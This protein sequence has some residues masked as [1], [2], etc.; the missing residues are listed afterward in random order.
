MSAAVLLAMPTAIAA[1][2]GDTGSVAPADD[3]AF[4]GMVA[5]ETAAA[6]TAPPAASTTTSAEPATPVAAPNQVHALVSAAVAFALQPRLAAGGTAVE[7]TGTAETDANV[8]AAAAESEDQPPADPETTIG[9]SDLSSRT[10]AADTDQ[11]A[12]DS[13]ASPQPA[14]VLL[15]E[16]VA[17][18]VKSAASDDA[19]NRHTQAA[20]PLPTATTPDQASLAP[21]EQGQADGARLEAPAAPTDASPDTSAL[22]PTATAA[23]AAAQAL[24]ALN[25]SPTQ[26]LLTLAPEQVSAPVA[27]RDPSRSDQTLTA[28]EPT[29]AGKD[30]LPTETPLSKTG[31]TETKSSEA[32][33]SETSPSQMPEGATS[34]TSPDAGKAM[35][36]V[37]PASAKPAEGPVQPLAPSVEPVETATPPAANLAQPSSAPAST[38]VTAQASTLSLLSQATI[39]TTAQIAAQISKTL[40]GRSTRFEMGLTPEGL[41]RVDVSLEIDA[42]GQLAARLAFDNPLAATELRGRVDDLRREL[43]DAGFTIARDGLEFA[44]RQSSS[45]GG[46]DRRQGR[47]FAS[48]SRI[49]ADADLSTPAPAAWTSL[50]LTPRGVDLKV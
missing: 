42:S 16:P 50:S 29:V 30:T 10:Q 6:D 20:A 33:S 14:V 21:A 11:S 46:F 5:V 45:G 26:T 3:S 22:S 24:A 17:V 9:A 1:P 19:A 31:P 47:A 44:E 7:S 43:Q 39:D 28:S 35:S 23:Q 40:A 37:A 27:K 34:R 2:S 48:A 32:K 38:A 25:V 18:S 8:P 13:A 41:G 12:S 15:P 36:D 49:A 4:A